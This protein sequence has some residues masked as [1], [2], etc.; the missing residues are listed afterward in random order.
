MFNLKTYIMTKSRLS[1]LLLAAALLV[2]SLSV[3]AEYVDENTGITYTAVDGS[4]NGNEGFADAC[5]GNVETKFGTGDKPNWL[6]IK[7][8][9]PV[10]LDGYTIFTANDNAS[11]T[12]RNPKDWT[13]EGSND[14]YHWTLLTEVKDDTVLQDVNFTPFD[15]ELKTVEAFTYFRFTVKA[16]QDAGAYM[17]YSELHLNGTE[18][19]PLTFEAKEGS[20]GFNNEGYSNV[21]DNNVNTKFCTNALPSW[22]IIE[23]S[24]PIYLTGYTI[25][26][27][28]DTKNSPGRNPK[29]WTI[30][31]S[32]DM[33]N[34]AVVT[35]V[36]NDQTMKAV[37]FTPFDFGMA[38]A[39]ESY[40]YFRFTVT[41]V[42]DGGLLQYSEL[43][44]KGSTAKSDATLQANGTSKFLWLPADPTI[45]GHLTYV[46]GEGDELANDGLTLNGK[47]ANLDDLE[48]SADAGHAL[49]TLDK[50][51]T[52]GDNMVFTTKGN[53]GL[54]FVFSNGFV[55]E[56]AL[57]GNQTKIVVPDEAIGSAAVIVTRTD[58]SSDPI[59]VTA[60]AIES[61]TF[62]VNSPWIGAEVGDFIA[63]FYNPATENFLAQGNAWGTQ[64]T[65]SE[66]GLR[67]QLTE[68]EDGLYKIV[69]CNYPNNQFGWDNGSG[70]YVDITNQAETRFD[71]QPAPGVENNDRVV[72][73]IKA[74]SVSRDGKNT[75]EGYL[76][77]NPDNTVVYVQDNIDEYCFW[78]VIDDTKRMLLEDAINDAT[79]QAHGKIALQVAD[80]AKAGYIWT[81]AQEPSEGPIANLLDRNVNTFFHT[82]WSV[83]SEDPHYLAVDLGAGENLKD[84]YL[85][86]TRRMNNNNNRPTEIVIAGSNDKENWTDFKTLTKEENA[87]PT[88]QGDDSYTS[89]LLSA[90]QAY[91]YLRFTVTHTNNEDRSR[92]SQ[93][94][95]F[96]FSEFGL[97]TPMPEDV[98]EAILD[99]VENAEEVLNDP[100][101]S[102]EDIDEAIETL[103]QQVKDI[104][105]LRIDSPF[106]GD[107]IADG[108]Y[109]VFYNPA[110]ANFL[111]QGN[112]WGTQA[113]RAAS[114][115]RFT[116]TENEEGLYKI[117][118]NKYPNCVFGWNA[119][120]QGDGDGG[121]YVDIT[122]QA[123]TTL[124]FERVETQD[125]DQFVYTIWVD[126]VSNSDATKVLG[127][128]LATNAENTVVYVVDAPNKFAYWQVVDETTKQALEDAIAVAQNK[129]KEYLTYNPVTLQTS[130]ETKDGYLW[131]NAPDEREGLH[132][133]DMLDGDVNTFFHSDWHGKVTETH[134]LQ[135]N[136]GEGKGLTNFAINYHRR[137]NNN[138]NR[139]TEIVIKGSN[140]G[141]N[142]TAIRTLTQAED[143]LPTVQGNDSY[144]SGL[145]SADKAYDYIRFDITKTNNNTIF[146]TFSE[147]GISNV[148]KEAG[149]DEIL[150][151]VAE[152]KAVLDNP[153]STKQEL[154]DARTKLLRAVFPIVDG[155]YYLYNKET[156]K[157]LSR[158]AAWGTQACLDDF[159]LPFVVSTPEAGLTWLSS[160]DWTDC[161]IS[162]TNGQDGGTF[163]D[164]TADGDLIYQYMNGEYI[165]LNTAAG[166]LAV[167]DNDNTKPLFGLGVHGTEAT[168]ARFQLLTPAEYEKM[169]SDRYDI[170]KIQAIASF[171][172]N[173]SDFEKL[174]ALD[175]T[176][177]VQ[178]ASL[179][180]S[181][182]GWTWTT[183][184]AGVPGYCRGGG[185]TTN[186]NGTETWQGC[187]VLSQTVEG[188]VSGLYKVTINGFYR[189]DGQRQGNIDWYN[190]GYVMSTAYLEA[191]GNK[192]R[193][194]PVGAEAVVNEAGDNIYPNW[195]WEAKACFEK[196]MYLN[197]VYTYVGEDGKLDISVVQPTW[198]GD[199]WLMLGGVTLTYYSLEPGALE[200]EEGTTGIN[201][202]EA[203][204]VS[205]SIFNANGTE[206]AE[207]AQGINIVKSVMSDGTIKVEKILVK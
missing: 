81:N 70:F 26:T 86:Y 58:A 126:G 166:Y 116:L 136:L 44:L 145:I 87:L 201:N 38:P 170:E 140:D 194:K 152:A 129:S 89:D 66:A 103:E 112:E 206:V 131:S 119:K 132:P 50:V 198:K 105:T 19:N 160:M 143:N 115:L 193:I 76:A 169:I 13:L 165:F 142:W 100:K 23:S 30:E 188:L 75:L 191:N 63:R 41:A 161:H 128:Y 56:Q 179:V 37:N 203:E 77:T 147:F 24:V 28:N 55:Y 31:G 72:Y 51:L 96:T 130:D 120:F 156:E 162:L 40:K 177:K 71:F 111:N 42:R 27:A 175:K 134:F 12:G 43:K 90:D 124:K 14:K 199:C 95:F 187:G 171:V 101:A 7:A 151:A 49:I 200:G 17:Q 10:Y 190:N 159:G 2:P 149:Y 79:D 185:L 174:Y 33:E 88:E 186:E 20:A 102:D 82:A 150:A 85:S 4:K 158:G 110:T 113:S 98:T 195:M 11:W 25:T 184:Q 36:K 117:V 148:T 83:A 139:P 125:P 61:Y 65:R 192:V 106:V 108:S 207:P 135:A 154:R 114:G 74:T 127:G 178:S 64:A 16:T 123:T 180:G 34:W 183:G 32:N 202:V 45:G 5:D 54:H 107:E 133:E 69:T 1:A 92:D 62:V 144:V 78:Q 80:E 196:G 68:Q 48:A 122:N 181:R 104:L 91:R 155:T 168:A 99:A 197:E 39:E 73:V 138:N 157:F 15:F 172:T 93:S 53:G 176:D 97:N 153:A 67:F 205:R 46:N 173:V 8:S 6:I 164:Q 189:I 204:V 21:C 59:V 60:I 57:T 35:E 29:D 47:A 9:K 118:T 52:K 84:F 163:V 109:W 167:E 182:D 18:V 121:F 3:K 146:F 22:V 141:E 137:M 94:L